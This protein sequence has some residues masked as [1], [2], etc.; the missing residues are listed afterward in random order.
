M[1]VTEKYIQNV[2]FMGFYK[3]KAIKFKECNTV[4]AKNQSEYYSLPVHRTDD[5]VVTS[6]WQLSFRQRLKVL[7]T[8]HIFLQI[9]TFNKPLQPLKMSVNKNELVA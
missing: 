9:L 8:G 2:Q 7:I 3:M 6:C 4:Y 5:G 1:H